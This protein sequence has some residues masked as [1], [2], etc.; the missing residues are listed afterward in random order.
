M[1]LKISLQ[2]FILDYILTMAL[3]LNTL[4]KATPN[5]D[6]VDQYLRTNIITEIRI[7]FDINRYTLENILNDIDEVLIIGD[8]SGSHES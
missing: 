2:Y 1:K 4:Y 5:F 6:D 7:N 3:D 8:V